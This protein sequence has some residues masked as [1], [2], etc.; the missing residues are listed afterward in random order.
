MKKNTYLV[1]LL[2]FSTLAFGQERIEIL[3]NGKSRV[4]S[5]NSIKI[6]NPDDRIEIKIFFN[7]PNTKDN[8][9]S[10]F[11]LYGCQQGNEQDEQKQQQQEQQQIDTSEIVF[12]KINFTATSKPKLKEGYLYTSFLTKDVTDCKGENFYV[13]LLYKQ[14]SKIQTFK[15]FRK[16]YKFYYAL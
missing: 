12:D 1:M 9:L 2:F 16:K 3:V 7:K 11:K 15:N 6:I 8:L 5:Q 13:E 4:L 10:S 14:N